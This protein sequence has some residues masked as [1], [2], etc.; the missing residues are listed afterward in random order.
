MRPSLN[1]YQEYQSN[2]INTADPKQLIIMLYDGAIRFLDT[3]ASYMGDFRTYDKANNNLLRAQDILTELMV[4]L[5]MEKGGE[6]A[7]NLLSLYIF[8]KKQLLE[9]NLKKSA[10]EVHK[11]SAMLR[12]LRNAWEQADPTRGMVGNAKPAGLQGGFVAQG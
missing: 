2:Q 4:S 3:A 7:R 9:A 1:P 6:I 10:A 12:D 8:M 11:V 5:D